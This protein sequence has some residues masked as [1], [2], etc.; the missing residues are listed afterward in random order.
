[1]KKVM[2]LTG[3][4]GSGKSTFAQRFCLENANW[5]RV[6]RDDLRRSLLPVSLGE[7][8][9]TWPDQ[10]KDRI[11]KL[12]SELQETAILEGL[13]RGWHVLIDNTNLRQSYVTMFRK[14]LSQHF[15][16][17]EISYKLI[18]TPLEECI[19][20]DSARPD[21]VGEAG[22]RHQAEQLAT[23]KANF[24][25]ESETVR[26]NNIPN[27]PANGPDTESTLP[28]C[29]LVDIDG[30]VAQSG[31]R[32]PFEWHRVGIDTPKW[33]VIRLVQSLKSSG[34]AIIFFSGR[35]AVCRSETMAWL[36]RYFGWI[37]G[38]YQLFMRTRNDNRKDFIIK[39]ELFD[40]HIRGRYQVELVLDDRQ[41]VVDLWRKTLK[42][43]CLQVDYGDF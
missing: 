5:L 10:E 41:Q 20:R 7:Y 34:H 14:L 29:V 15:D 31:N 19:R 18:D 9:K 40:Q 33:P 2:I 25:F 22:I 36:E 43:T 32:S 28:T 24:K 26:R 27:R 30:T 42:L 35:D 37:S 13:R 11:E 16:E 17:V 8:W 4:S 38:D 23:L 39:H 21:S 3:L 1:M 12:V 6:N